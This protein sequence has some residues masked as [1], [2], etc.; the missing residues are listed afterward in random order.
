[1]TC[2]KLEEE[3]LISFFISLEVDLYLDYSPEGVP[4]AAMVKF[5]FVIFSS[6]SP[7]DL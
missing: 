5:R 2:Q 3:V 6:E 1:M 7:K 4:V